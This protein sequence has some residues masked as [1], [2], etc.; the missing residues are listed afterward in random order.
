MSGLVGYG[1]SDEEDDRIE[2]DQGSG[3]DVCQ[4]VFIGNPIPMITGLTGQVLGL[5]SE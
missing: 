4:F 1:T 2:A 3:V 5:T